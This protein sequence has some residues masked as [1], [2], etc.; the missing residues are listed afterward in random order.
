MNREGPL[1]RKNRRTRGTKEG[2]G[3]RAEG[4]Q[5]SVEERIASSIKKRC[6]IGWDGGR[7]K[8]R[9]KYL[10]QE[11][12]RTGKEGTQRRRGRD[13][14][15]RKEK[16]RAGKVRCTSLELEDPGGGRKFTTDAEQL[17][18]Q[19]SRLRGSNHLT[20]TRHSCHRLFGMGAFWKR[21]GSSRGRR[22][23]PPPLPPPPPGRPAYLCS[24]GRSC[25]SL[26]GSGVLGMTLKM[27]LCSDVP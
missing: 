12:K 24:G 27:V 15:E 6:N 5:G 2:G 11:D 18:V 7:E 4:R 17:T 9:S 1:G 25:A 23:R 10:S 8:R 19:F 14:E 21:R 13:R 22:P 20:V 3:W 16:S 26:A